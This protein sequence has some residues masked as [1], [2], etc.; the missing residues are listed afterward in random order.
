[1][2][3]TYFISNCSWQNTKVGNG[4]FLNGLFTLNKSLNDFSLISINPN[5]KFNNSKERSF[6]Y[7]EKK[8][9]P[10]KVIDIILYFFCSLLRNTDK[11]INSNYILS[12]S[13][14]EYLNIFLIKKYQIKS[15]LMIDSLFDDYYHSKNIFKNIFSPLAY[16]VE[17]L[18]II[19]GLE[20]I[21]LNSEIVATKFKSRYNFLLKICKV[22]VSSSSIWI[23]DQSL[24]IAHNTI[25]NNNYFLI[26]GNFDFNQNYH[27]VEEFAL[28]VKKNQRH[29]KHKID[30]DLII[31]GKSA[32]R[33]KLESILHLKLIFKNVE[34]KP[35][36]RIIED[37]IKFSNAVIVAST[38]AN[39]PKI[40]VLESCLSNKLTLAHKNVASFYPDRFPNLVKYKKFKDLYEI[41]KN[42]K[43][44]HEVQVSKEIRSKWSKENRIQDL[45]LKLNL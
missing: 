22:K 25:I 8:F 44:F 20:R 13:T 10:L 26:H 36:P 29:F 6:Y 7:K 9:S 32:D 24:D 40:K 41:L 2:S 43:E 15:Y 35:N 37:Y 42:Y 28:S 12:T 11:K 30:S 31:A 4:Y 21:I 5:N 16:I 45:I 33:I 23:N 18:Y 14:L 3:K 27:G 38:E 34:I 19:S 1:M 17:C 39:G